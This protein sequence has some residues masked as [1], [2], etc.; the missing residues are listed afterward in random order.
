MHRRRMAE[1]VR[2]YA[3]G[4]KT[5]HRLD[6]CG[7]IALNDVGDAGSTEWPTIAIEEQVVVLVGR[8][9][10]FFDLLAQMGRRAVPKWTCP[11][12]AAFAE[13]LN[14]AW[15]RQRQP[16]DASI[17]NLLDPSSCVVHE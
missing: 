17:G 2:R 5:W 8:G 14:L 12:F 13:Q 15:R 10:A 11:P 3:Q 1:R 7:R 6:G 9:A 16:G 4:F